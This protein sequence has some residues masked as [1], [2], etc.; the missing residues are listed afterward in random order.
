MHWT[1]SDSL[2]AFYYLTLKLQHL[3]IFQ[4]MLLFHIQ[5]CMYL[6]IFQLCFLVF[7]FLQASSDSSTK[8]PFLCDIYKILQCK[9]IPSIITLFKFI[10]SISFKTIISFVL[11][12][13]IKIIYCLY[14]LCYNIHYILQGRCINCLKLFFYA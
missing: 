8:Y 1:L 5:F 3:N 2:E 7:T 13:S 10:P 4:A 14:Y 6:Y 9:T 12:Q 11:L